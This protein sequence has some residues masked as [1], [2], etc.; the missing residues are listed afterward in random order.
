ME[1]EV[2]KL[3]SL[4]IEELEAR[5]EFTAVAQEIMSAE[6]FEAAV[7]TKPIKCGITIEF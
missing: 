4:S 7:A 1:K 2:T 6:D 3:S 5:V